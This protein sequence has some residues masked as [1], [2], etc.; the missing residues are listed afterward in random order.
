MSLTP[1]RIASV[2]FAWFLTV[3]T[4]MSCGKTSLVMNDDQDTSDSIEET[5]T[6][7]E[8]GEEDVV[9]GESVCFCD[10]EDDCCDGCMPINEEGVRCS[11]LYGPLQ[12]LES[13]L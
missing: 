6:E 12:E 8:M 11:P 2:G 1:V 7:I 3:L 9:E 13:G 4:L 5:A 10:T